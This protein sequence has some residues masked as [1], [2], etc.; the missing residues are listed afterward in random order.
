MHCYGNT[1]F[2][3]KPWVTEGKDPR[4]LANSYLIEYCNNLDFFGYTGGVPKPGGFLSQLDS[5]ALL[6]YDNLTGPGAY[7]DMDMLQCCNGGQTQAE[8]RSQFAVWAILTSPLIL[9]NDLTNMDAACREVVLNPEVIA[10]SQDKLVSRGRLVSQWPDF[11]WPNQTTTT[12]GAAP[13]QTMGLGLGPCITITPTAGEPAQT[14]GLG[15]GPCNISN[16]SQHFMFNASAGSLVA[17]ASG[18]C[19]T[20]FGYEESNTGLA[21][22]TDWTGPGVGGQRWTFQNNSLLNVGNSEKCLDVFN[23]DTEAHD[24]VQTCTCGSSDCFAAASPKTCAGEN[25]RWT[26]DHV[27]PLSQPWTLDSSDL[28][29]SLDNSGAVS[30]VSTHVDGGATCLSAREMPHSTM[31]ITTQVWM[32][33]LSDGSVAVVI[34]NRGVTK[35]PVTIPWWLISLATA[36]TCVVRDLWQRE[37]LGTFLHNVTV[38]V[39]P[40]DVRA[41]KVS[42][43]YE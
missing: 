1:V 17:V 36:K 33:E 41:L 43:C 39:G 5:Q 9:G 42:S 11:T 29:W 18:L 4:E 7:S 15:L 12:L 34:L 23:C 10:I 38:D 25:L 20:Y 2:T 31:N 26:L 28:P 30:I 8:Y 35:I 21:T 6:T 16:T 27:G 14:M 22:C 40:H 19:V 32:K 37:D 24:A 3:I 13:A